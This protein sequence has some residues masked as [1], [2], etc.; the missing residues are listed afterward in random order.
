MEEDTGKSVMEVDLIFKDDS[1]DVRSS[2]DHWLLASILNDGCV[3]STVFS[4]ILQTN[5]VFRKI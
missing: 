2:L 1:T 5:G 3:S 4:R